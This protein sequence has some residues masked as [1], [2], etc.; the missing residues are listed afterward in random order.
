MDAY[1]GAAT[2][3]ECKDML[4][5]VRD[6]SYDTYVLQNHNHWGVI[7]TYLLVSLNTW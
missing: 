6:S 5:S 2:L 7:P 1:D 4:K 3:W